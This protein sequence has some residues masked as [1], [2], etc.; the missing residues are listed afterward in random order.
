[1]KFKWIDKKFE[2]IWH[3]CVIVYVIELNLFYYEGWHAVDMKLAYILHE[4]DI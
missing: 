4:I 1:M 2:Y 3:T